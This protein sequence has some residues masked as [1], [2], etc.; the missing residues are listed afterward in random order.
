[1]KLHCH[2]FKGTLSREW[3]DNSVYDLV[4]PEYVVFLLYYG[5]LRAFI[6]F[7]YYQNLFLQSVL[8]NDSCTQVHFPLLLG[9]TGVL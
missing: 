3:N 7:A 5:D 6:T 8:S 9:N 2:S 1:M 4:V